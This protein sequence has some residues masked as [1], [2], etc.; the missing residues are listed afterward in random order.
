[1][2]VKFVLVFTVTV[3]VTDSDSERHGVTCE[4]LLTVMGLL[5]VI[6][7]CDGVVHGCVGMYMYIWRVMMGTTIPA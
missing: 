4:L 7:F 5:T 3:T 2:I 6:S 1:M